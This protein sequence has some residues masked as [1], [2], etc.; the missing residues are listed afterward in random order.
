MSEHEK[1]QLLASMKEIYLDDDIQV[2]NGKFLEKTLNN[3][4][5]ES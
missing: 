5:G 3:S 1:R 2:D 4:I